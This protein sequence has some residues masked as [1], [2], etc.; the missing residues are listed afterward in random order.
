VTQQFSADFLII[1]AGAAG[2]SVAR[3]LC[4]VASVIVLE[5]EDTPGYHATSRSAAIFVDSYGDEV[6]QRLTAASRPLLDAPPFAVD[7][8]LLARPRGLLY[9]ARTTS[10]A[11]SA[12]DGRARFPVLTGDETRAL[13]PILR[14]TAIAYAHWEESAADIDVHALLT[15][16]QRHLKK[17]GGRI[18]AAA[19][20]TAARR[21]AGIWTLTAGAST[22]SAPIVINAA[23]AWASEVGRLLG[24]RDLPLIPFRRTAM[25]VAPPDGVDVSAWPMVVDLEESVYF[26]P[27]A[28]VLMLSPA[29]ET[30]VAAHD[31]YAEDL[32]VAIAVDRFESLTDCSVRRVL[33]KWAGLR[34]MAP[35]RR[36]VI[37]FDPDVEGL[38]W[39]AGQGGFGIQTALGAAALSR[40][41][42]GA[43]GGANAT[44]AGLAP[45]VSPARLSAQGVNRLFEQATHAES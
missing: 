7:S 5:R 19:P 9:V 11:L 44:L 40:N 42:I 41:L 3:E 13:V 2:L 38:F 1:G 43:G 26:K 31:A 25:T 10:P 20:V 33:A 28:G 8:E 27:D 32:D 45:L 39:L 23:G 14:E 4:E 6:I 15:G 24:A 30:P 18:L 34:T 17:R 22:V 16:L 37:G 21:A 29:D 36:P 35:D 12:T